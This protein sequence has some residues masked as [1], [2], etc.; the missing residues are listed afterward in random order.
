M[1]TSRPYKLRF[2]YDGTKVCPD[3]E[4]DAYVIDDT[5][6]INALHSFPD[7]ET[8]MTNA[9]GISR[10]GGH[11]EVFHRDSATKVATPIRTFEPYE[12]AMEDLVTED[13]NKEMTTSE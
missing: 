10:R 2:R 4:S 7:K 3:I 12:V 13:A 11:A 1:G 9:R 8:A 5:R 6:P